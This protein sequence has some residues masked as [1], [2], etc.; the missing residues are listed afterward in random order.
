MD[1]VLAS[2]MGAVIG[3]LFGIAGGILTGLR[4]AKLE[5]DRWL[6]TRQD[7]IERETRLAV[8]ELAKKMAAAT[9]VIL[10][11]TAK[12]NLTPNRLTQ[13]DI[14]GYD[15]DIQGLLP[16]ILG[17]LMVVSALDPEASEKM[18]PLR[19]EIFRV[20]AR[21]AQ[22]SSQFDKSPESSVEAIA[23]FFYEEAIPLN[24][25]L[26]QTISGITGVAGLGD[27]SIKDITPDR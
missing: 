10:W 3:G 20:N 24:S 19:G 11:L 12:A 18:S 4:Q 26:T 21:I 25:K 6:R 16:D 9:Q 17:S 27:D 7:D 13:E 15:K 5:K 22:A 8:A 1:P 2:L 23:E 14:T